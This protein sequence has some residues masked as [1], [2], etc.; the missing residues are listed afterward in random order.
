MS[1]TGGALVTG[2]FRTRSNPSAGGSF[3]GGA[4]VP[5]AL[6]PP[7]PPPLPPSSSA[8]ISAPVSTPS[9]PGPLAFADFNRD[10]LHF[11]HQDLLVAR[12]PLLKGELSSP[13]HHQAP[14]HQ[15]VIKSG[16]F[17]RKKVRS[18]QLV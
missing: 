18:H 2:H 6:P 15:H 8:A 16:S 7:P 5:A 11:A 13:P 4:A 14:Q 12:K 9:S 3:D 17:R 1:G 10:K